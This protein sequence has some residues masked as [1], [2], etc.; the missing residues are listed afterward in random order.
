MAAYNGGAQFVTVPWIF[1]TI[2][3]HSGVN[4]INIF[5]CRFFEA[6]L[7]TANCDLQMA[8]STAKCDLRVAQPAQLLYEKAW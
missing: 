1:A 7:R 2:C 4:V 8:T 5:M 6:F 3:F